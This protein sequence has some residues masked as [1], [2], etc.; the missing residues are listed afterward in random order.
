MVAYWRLILSPGEMR[1]IEQCEDSCNISEDEIS[2][3]E[4]RDLCPYQSCGTAELDD[5]LRWSQPE[6]I[7]TVAVRD[8]CLVISILHSSDSHGIMIPSPAEISDCFISSR[9]SCVNEQLRIVFAE[10]EE[11][12]VQNVT[13]TLQLDKLY[14]H[15]NVSSLLIHSSISNNAIPE[16]NIRQRLK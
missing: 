7:L 6:K 9:Q 13:I 15:L 3:S 12:H 5:L 16:N 10:S 11:Y 8:H 4:R 14:V 2:S 1:S